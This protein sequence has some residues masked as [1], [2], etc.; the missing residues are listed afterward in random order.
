MKQIQSTY[1]VIPS[2]SRPWLREPMAHE[3]LSPQASVPKTG[4]PLGMTK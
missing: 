2:E 3:I 4:T 1:Y